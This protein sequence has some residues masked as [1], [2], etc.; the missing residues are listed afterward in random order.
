MT[1]FLVT[2][3]TA[4]GRKREITLVADNPAEARRNLRKRGILPTTLIRKESNPHAT[5]IRKEESF[6]LN[7]LFESKISV[8]EKA[9]FANKLSAMVDAGVPIM[10]GLDL[11]KRQQKSP[12]FRRALTAMT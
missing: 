4:S 11:I 12:L 10:R 6:D 1:I 2:Y 5:A 9:L 8:K 3:A 7:S